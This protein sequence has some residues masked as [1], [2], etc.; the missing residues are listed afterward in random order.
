MGP[1]CFNPALGFPVRGF[2]SLQPGISKAKPPSLGETLMNVKA[3]NRTLA[4]IAAVQ[5]RLQKMI[6]HA[7]TLAGDGEAPA[8]ARGPAAKKV[9][10]KKAA[11]KKVVA[12]KKAPAKKVAAK[13]VAKKAPPARK[14]PATKKVAGK[15]GAV[16]KGAVKKSAKKV[17]DDESFPDVD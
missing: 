14:G 16:K 1:L 11:G 15:K 6:E 10:A 3:M 2:G 5:A 17:V 12:A 8:K 9:A 4:R 7:K 13:R